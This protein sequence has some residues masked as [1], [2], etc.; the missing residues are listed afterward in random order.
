MKFWLKPLIAVL[1]GL[2]QAD[3][4]RQRQVQKLQKQ[5]SYFQHIWIKLHNKTSKLSHKIYQLLMLINYF[6]SSIC[7]LEIISPTAIHLKLQK[8]QK[9]PPL[10][11]QL[12][13]NTNLILNL[14]K[15]S[16]VKSG[17]SPMCGTTLKRLNSL[18]PLILIGPLC[19]RKTPSH[20][21]DRM[22]SPPSSTLQLSLP[23]LTEGI[24]T[25]LSVEQVKSLIKECVNQTKTDVSKK[26]SLIALRQIIVLFK[27][28]RLAEVNRK[29]GR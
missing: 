20:I 27:I 15:V 28:S 12:A 2:R 26:P 13:L 11:K 7:A 17:E 8:V 5:A 3:F 21:Y 1:G 29:C 4:V 14:E 24:L 6:K 19:L 18:I 10:C 22:P 25:V 16:A 23:P 9:N